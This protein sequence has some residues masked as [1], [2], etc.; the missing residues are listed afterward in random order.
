MHVRSLVVLCLC[1]PSCEADP[2]DGRILLNREACVKVSYLPERER[3]EPY[4][5]RN[6]VE[7]QLDLDELC[8]RQ[9][10]KRK[11]LRS[12]QGRGRGGWTQ[13]VSAARIRTRQEGSRCTGYAA[14]RVGWMH[15]F[16]QVDEE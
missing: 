10:L 1:T 5:C 12:A 8:S 14:C 9:K 4:R 15:V 6:A 13:G 11:E 3:Y 7:H 2:H 16:M